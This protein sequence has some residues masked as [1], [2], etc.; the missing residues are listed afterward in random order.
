MIAWNFSG[1][2]IILLFLNQLIT[3]PNS[4]RKVVFNSLTFFAMADKG[5]SS[6]KLYIYALETKKNKSYIKKLNRIGPVLCKQLQ[7][8]NQTPK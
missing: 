1:L 8:I 7:E 3:T 4:D 6:L 5:L 2:T